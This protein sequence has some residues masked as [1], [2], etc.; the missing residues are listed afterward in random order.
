MLGKSDD[1]A[2]IANKGMNI[3]A[4]LTLIVSLTASFLFNIN[5]HLPMY[6]CIIICLIAFIMYFFMK[7]I[8]Q[9]NIVNLNENNKKMKIKFSKTVWAIFII[10]AIFYGII[11][12]GQQNTKLLIQYNLADI[13]NIE[14]VSIYLG[15]IIVFSRLSRLIGSVVFGKVYYKIKDKS[16][17]IL[18]SILVASFILT[19]IG[20]LVEL[21]ALKFIL[22]TIG[23]CIILA[24]RDP[25]KL[26]INDIVLKITKNEEK[27]KAI[28]Y[29]GFSRKFGM[30]IGSLLVSAVLLKWKMIY[31]IIGIG[32]LSII[33]F[34][35]A[36]K[37]Y[38][39]L[40]VKNKD[41]NTSKI[42]E[43]VKI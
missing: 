40:K 9:N 28:S 13:Y 35:I 30:T 21:S 23:F 17:L 31:V 14:K 2:K 6:L 15:I 12:N 18:S 38:S 5:P 34:L 29:I 22:M 43:K 27:Q 24:V 8:S 1:Y 36:I 20:F 11:V 41:N 42:K 33:D 10:Y 32:I 25:F 26:Y 37:L 3:Y 4:F 39:M 16:L 7:D 19:T